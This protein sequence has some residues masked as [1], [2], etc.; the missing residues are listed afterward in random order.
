[1]Y[2]R[3]SF[4]KQKGRQ[5]L[6]FG[7]SI[8]KYIFT[9]KKWEDLVRVLRLGKHQAAGHHL[10]QSIPKRVD[11]VL[12]NE[13]HRN[14]GIDRIAHPIHRRIATNHPQNTRIQAQDT[15]GETRVHHHLTEV[16][17]LGVRQVH[18]IHLEVA[19]VQA[20]EAQANQR[21]RTD[22]LH[23]QTNCKRGNHPHRIWIK[24]VQF[25]RRRHQN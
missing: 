1:M 22:P 3:H 6:V 8:I 18:Q 4:K 12:Q 9:A 15:K 17:D 5:H 7:I 23:L 25:E 20:A 14:I 16:V 24:F 10:V 2:K 13:N 21:A 19:A 11:I